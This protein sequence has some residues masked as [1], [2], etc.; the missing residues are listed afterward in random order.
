MD[1][2]NK[3]ADLKPNNFRVDGT[4]PSAMYDSF[5]NMRTEDLLE[6]K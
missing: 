4:V 2:K 6:I 5:L 1:K 3:I